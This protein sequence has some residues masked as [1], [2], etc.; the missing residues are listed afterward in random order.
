MVLCLYTPALPLW[1]AGCAAAYAPARLATYAR[2]Q[3][4]TVLQLFVLWVTFPAFSLPRHG[5]RRWV[6]AAPAVL[7]YWIDAYRLLAPCI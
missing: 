6:I 5:L 2:W 1:T 3:T 7:I 4:L